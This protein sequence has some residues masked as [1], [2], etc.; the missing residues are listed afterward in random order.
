MVCTFGS[1]RGIDAGACARSASTSPRRRRWLVRSGSY[2]TSSER[3]VGSTATTPAGGAAASRASRAST[4]SL[5]ASE[6]SSP[7]STSRALSAAARKRGTMAAY[8]RSVRRVD[9][10][11]DAGEGY[12]PWRM[13]DDEALLDVVT[14]V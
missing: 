3:N 8:H 9:L 10:N 11:C 1:A 5:T 7:S 6:T 12:G 13:G 14:T 2:S 4:A